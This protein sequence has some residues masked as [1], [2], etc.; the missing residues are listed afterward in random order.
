MTH[1]PDMCTD[2][3]GM[4]KGE[5]GTSPGSRM[6][7]QLHI[8]AHQMRMVASADA[9]ANTAVGSRLVC[10]AYKQQIFV[11]SCFVQ[12]LLPGGFPLRNEVPTARSLVSC[13]SLRL[14]HCIPQ[15]LFKS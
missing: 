15:Q 4:G 14:L 3:K 6:R 10:L 8:D 11:R 1:L 13:S 2:R 12:D 5:W 9:L 7:I